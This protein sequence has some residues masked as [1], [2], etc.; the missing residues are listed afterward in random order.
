MG[1]VALA[2]ALALANSVAMRVDRLLALQG[3][4]IVHHGAIVIRSPAGV[5][6]CV[7]GLIEIVF[8]R[9]WYV[10]PDDGHKVVP[11]RA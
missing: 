7:G 1:N 11:V 8:P 2:R 3:S 9:V 5:D 6:L 4:T 10:F